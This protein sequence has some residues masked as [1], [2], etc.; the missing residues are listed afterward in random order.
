MW[1]ILLKH[2]TFCHFL[3]SDIPLIGL[4]N[5]SLKWSIDKLH[6]IVH[7]R[8]ISA[9]YNK[10]CNPKNTYS[11]LY[12]NLLKNY[13]DTT[14]PTF[15]QMILD[16]ADERGCYIASSCDI[17]GH[18]KWEKILIT[19]GTNIKDLFFL[20]QA[21]LPLMQVLYD[22]LRCHR[23]YGGFLSRLSIH[24]KEAK[25]DRTFREWTS[26]D[27]WHQGHEVHI[28]DGQDQCSFF[29]AQQGCQAEALPVV[30][31]GLWNVWL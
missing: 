4:F 12:H 31:D 29:K 8:I 2:G 6:P 3:L 19:S 30:Q 28:T 23:F 10:V 1:M 14:W 18:I 7:F 13:D 9:Y 5:L 22:K 26:G 27:Q 17:D 11:P 15:A 24:S 20:P 16:I 21:L 25:P